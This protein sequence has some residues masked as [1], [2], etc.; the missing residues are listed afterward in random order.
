MRA[1]AAYEGTFGVLVRVSL[2]TCKKKKEAL[3]LEESQQQTP[4]SSVCVRVFIA[5]RVCNG[6]TEVL[7]TRFNQRT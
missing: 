6:A 7:E 4:H 3:T 2:L 5:Q 1:L